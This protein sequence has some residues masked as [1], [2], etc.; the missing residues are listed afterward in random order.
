[1]VKMI[2]VN[3]VVAHR[4]RGTRPT[5]TQ[6]DGGVRNVED[7]VVL[8][9]DLARVTHVDADA[10]PVVVGAIGDDVVCDADIRADLALVSRIVR[11]MS[12]DRAFLEF[13]ED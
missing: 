12:F 5:P 4:V 2:R 7:L 3:A 9:R 13:T 8:D 11:E 1:M 10:A 6:A